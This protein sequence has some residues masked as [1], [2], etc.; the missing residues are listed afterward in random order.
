MVWAHDPNSDHRRDLV[1]EE[2]SAFWAWAIVEVLRTTGIRAEEL[3][4]LS[5]HALVQYRLPTTGEVIPLLQVVPSKTD[6]ERLL[7][8]IIKSTH[9]HQDV[10]PFGFVVTLSWRVGEF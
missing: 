5:H 7:V 9:S 4:E 1:R 8:V 3:L 10:L 6:T 2:D